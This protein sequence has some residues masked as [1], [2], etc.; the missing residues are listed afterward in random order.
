MALRGQDYH[1]LSLSHKTALLGTLAVACGDTAVVLDWGL[2]VR[3]L[4]SAG[5]AAGDVGM[6]RAS[7]RG[8]GVG[9]E[10]EGD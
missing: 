1:T 9:L 3:E 6:R 4:A 5:G 2:V 7:S 8:R 10:R